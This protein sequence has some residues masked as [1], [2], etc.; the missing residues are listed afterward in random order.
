MYGTVE[1]ITRSDKKL[2]CVYYRRAIANTLV[3]LQRPLPPLFT[4]QDICTFTQQLR[5]YNIYFE[6]QDGEILFI[7]II[8][9]VCVFVSSRWEENFGCE[10]SQLEFTFTS[11]SDETHS[12]YRKSTH[13]PLT[14]AMATWISSF[15]RFYY[16]VFLLLLPNLFIFS[17]QTFVIL[18]REQ[19]N[20]LQAW[21][22]SYQ[23]T[24]IPVFQHT[25]IP[26]FFHL[27][28][29]TLQLS[30]WESPLQFND[31]GSYAR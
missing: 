29:L 4:T 2:Q 3:G 18:L 30:S 27:L 13:P 1:I 21:S 6:A 8:L 24:S 12:E 20:N 31:N 11:T 28:S 16:S 19:F 7:W 10:V 25:S 23:H 15:T 17:L 22:T 9:L 5:S 14:F 26:V